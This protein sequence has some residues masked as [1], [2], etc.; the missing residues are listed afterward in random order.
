MLLGTSPLQASQPTVQVDSANE[1]QFVFT[2]LE[3]GHSYGL[4]W[5]S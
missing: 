2:E 5:D 4:T 1:V 3:R